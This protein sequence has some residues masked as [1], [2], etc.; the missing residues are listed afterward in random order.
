M[1]EKQ[2]YYILI[3]TGEKTLASYGNDGDFIQKCKEILSQIKPDSSA[4]VDCDTFL[5]YYLN[6]NNLT[7]MLATG[8]LYPK[9][10]AIGCI[11]SLQKEFNDLAFE[12]NLDNLKE[13]GLNKE[14]GE[15]L[16][17]KFEYYNENTDVSSEALENLKK[18]IVEMKDE[19]FKAKDLLEIRGDKM[20]KTH[21]AAI[22]LKDASSSY[23]I[24]AGK[25]RKKTSCF[26]KWVYF[27]IFFSLIIIIY[28]IICLACKSWTFQC[29]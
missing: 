4:A 3:G 24:G 13:N 1:T 27:A 16:K 26:G 11:D 21:Q 19:V 2:I 17:M 8:K 14:I 22:E 15:K 28:F 10:T 7:Y 9:T 20:D 25:V 12:K 6:K 29:K 18:E 23:R 5:V